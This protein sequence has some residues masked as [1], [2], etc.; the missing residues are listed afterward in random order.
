MQRNKSNQG[1]EAKKDT[2]DPEAPAP[3]AAGMAQKCFQKDTEE[4]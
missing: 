2:K 4:P 3:E 1:L